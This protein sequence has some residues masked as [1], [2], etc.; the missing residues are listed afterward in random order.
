[1]STLWTR[2]LSYDPHG[3]PLLDGVDLTAPPGS[4]TGILGPNGA[5][6]STLLRA[7]I[8]ALRST[9]EVWFGDVNASS[10]PRR[11][12][13]RRLALVEQEATTLDDL[14]VTE[15]V[16]LGR[17]PYRNRFGTAPADHD[18][19]IAD[20]LVRAG[21]SEFADRRLATLS[22]GERQRVHLARALAQTPRVL[23]LDEPTNHLDIAAQ[24]HLLRVVTDVADRGAAVLLAIHDLALAARV[25]TDAVV[26]DRGRVVAAGPITQVLTPELI[27]SV[28]KVQAEWVRGASG[29]ALVLS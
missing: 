20:A 22:G 29:T 28:W 12:R 18:D 13:A 26:L 23:L 24:L 10:L 2:A 16:A 7:V 17:I 8:G 1:M 3:V 9:G 5:G 25:C 19:V 27:S 21:A 14:T 11:E 15:A 6:K 4:I